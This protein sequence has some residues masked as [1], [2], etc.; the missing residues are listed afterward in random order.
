MFRQGMEK[1]KKNKAFILPC[2]AD[3]SADFDYLK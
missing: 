2:P 1:S 3:F